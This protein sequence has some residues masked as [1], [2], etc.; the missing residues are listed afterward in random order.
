MTA[1]DPFEFDDDDLEDEIIDLEIENEELRRAA[2]LVCPYAM[3]SDVLRALEQQ[4]Q[5]WPARRWHELARLIERS[6]D[7]TSTDRRESE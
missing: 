6:C 4:L 3:P 7:L 1:D 2:E 5:A